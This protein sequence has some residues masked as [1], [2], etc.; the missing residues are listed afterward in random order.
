MDK[1]IPGEIVRIDGDPVSREQLEKAYPPELFGSE[2]GLSFREEL[3]TNTGSQSA[4]EQPILQT[5]TDLNKETEQRKSGLLSL[6][7][8]VT[9]DVSEILGAIQSRYLD[10]VLDGP[11]SDLSGQF[12]EVESPAGTGVKVGTWINRGDGYWALRLIQHRTVVLDFHTTDES[13][14]VFRSSPQLVCHP[15]CADELNGKLHLI[16]LEIGHVKLDD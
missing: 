13:G 11:P 12:V 15:E 7:V 5:I 10:I 16:L 6:P 8:A 1:K 4:V 2:P 9:V 14:D 3:N